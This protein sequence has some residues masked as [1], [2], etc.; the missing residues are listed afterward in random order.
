MLHF[1]KEMK[2]AVLVFS[3][4]FSVLFLFFK[5]HDPQ[6]I[7]LFLL[8]TLIFHDQGECWSPS[9]MIHRLGKEI[10]NPDSVYYW[11]YKVM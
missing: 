3:F 2:L 10:D 4:Q 11:A 9:S 8:S 1:C 6:E 7:T 5:E